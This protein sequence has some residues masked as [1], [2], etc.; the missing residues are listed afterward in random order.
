M[1]KKRPCDEFRT[2]GKEW[3]GLM[4]QSETDKFR[5]GSVPWESRALNANA[6]WIVDRNREGYSFIDIGGDGPPNKSPFYAVEKQ[7]L[8]QIGAKVYK[9]APTAISEARKNSKPSARPKS[10]VLC[11][12]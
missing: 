9:G 10:K 4:E 2:I 8:H 11:L 6:D 3:P 7:T 1:R 5:I 12:L